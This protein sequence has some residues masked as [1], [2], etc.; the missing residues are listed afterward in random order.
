MA[1]LSKYNINSNPYCLYVKSRD[2][3][4]TH[5]IRR[6]PRVHEKCKEGPFCGTCYAGMGECV[7]PIR[8]VDGTPLAFISVSGYRLAPDQALARISAVAERYG[9]A[10]QK[11]LDSYW[12]DLKPEQPD[13]EA[14]SV[15]IA[16]LC[17]MFELLHVMLGSYSQDSVGSMTQSCILGHA[18]VYLRRHYSEDLSLD[19]VAEYVSLHPSYLSYLFKKKTGD[20]FLHFLHTVRLQEACRLMREKPDLPLERISELVGYRTSTYF[21]KAF[22]QHFG[23]SP[24]DW[25]KG[26]S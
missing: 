13:L 6:Q 11:L 16:P 8:S 23:K 20:S 22:R 3:A 4:W 17:R 12:N 2:T 21:Y 26:K 10:R 24:R 25:Q 5:C 7:F 19:S 9:H 14:L 15:Q 1:A 18:V